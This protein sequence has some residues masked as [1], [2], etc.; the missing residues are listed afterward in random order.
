MNQLVRQI[1][2][3]AYLRRRIQRLVIKYIEGYIENLMI[4]TS[5]IMFN[6]KIKKK[7]SVGLIILYRSSN[8]L[9]IMCS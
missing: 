9:L 4:I 1:F 5:T 2:E 8:D 3:A 6:A 7:H